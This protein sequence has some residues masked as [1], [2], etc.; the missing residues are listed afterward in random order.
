M[1]SMKIEKE[2]NNKLN[3]LIA[4]LQESFLVEAVQNSLYNLLVFCVKEPISFSQR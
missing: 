3:K 4:E 2:R 1:K